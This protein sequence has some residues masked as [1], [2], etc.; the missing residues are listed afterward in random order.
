MGVVFHEEYE[1]VYARGP[2]AKAGGIESIVAPLRGHGSVAP[3]AATERVF[4]WS[5]V[6]L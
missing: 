4:S 2:A 3:Q 1:L 6:S 5:T